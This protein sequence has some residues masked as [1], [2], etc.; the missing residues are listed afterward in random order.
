MVSQW[1]TCISPLHP[2]IS[3]HILHTVLYTFPLVQTRRISLTIKTW[4]VGNHFFCSHN[5]S[6]WFRN[7]TVRRNLML[8]TCMVYRIKHKLNT[9]ILILDGNSKYLLKINLRSKSRSSLFLN[10]L[11]TGCFS[12][13]LQRS[14]FYFFSSDIWSIC[15]L[16]LISQTGC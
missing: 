10:L 1:N 16:Q 11:Q 2:Y 5:L 8:V 14:F 4:L 7:I 15:W 6:E 12:V 9:K 13:Y 3:I